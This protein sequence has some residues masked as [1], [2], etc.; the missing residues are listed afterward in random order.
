MGSKGRGEAP[1]TKPSSQSLLIARSGVRVYSSVA[2]RPST[3]PGDALPPPSTNQRL[4][5]LNPLGAAQA[6]A[7]NVEQAGPFLLVRVAA[8]RLQL[9]QCAGSHRLPQ[10]R[11][12]LWIAQVAAVEDRKERHDIGGE[13]AGL[14][15]DSDH[16]ALT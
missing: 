16:G 5:A 12:Q 2:A 6:H 11:F 9:E 13:A 15:H 14:A 7:W 4:L 3:A 1:G 10:G 8:Q